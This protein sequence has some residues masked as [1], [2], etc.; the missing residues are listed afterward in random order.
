MRRPLPL[1]AAL[2]PPCSTL[3]SAVMRLETTAPGAHSHGSAKPPFMRGQRV[4]SDLKR[5][6]EGMGCQLPVRGDHKEPPPPT[7]TPLTS[8]SRGAWGGGQSWYRQPCLLPVTAGSETLLGLGEEHLGASDQHRALHQPLPPSAP[9]LE[10][11]MGSPKLQPRVAG[12]VGLQDGRASFRV[13][14]W[15]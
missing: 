7:S 10:E 14:S 1:H 9:E 12:G 8:K 2:C 15:A 13:P 11:R 4:G 5:T 3:T 6:Q